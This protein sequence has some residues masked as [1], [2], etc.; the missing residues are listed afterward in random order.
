MKHLTEI[1]DW[2]AFLI[3]SVPLALEARRR[4]PRHKRR[5]VTIQTP[6]ATTVLSAPSPRVVTLG[7]AEE[8]NTALPVGIQAALGKVAYLD[9]DFPQF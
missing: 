6:P 5:D 1:R 2:L 3:G 4:R 8:R 7:I 9:P